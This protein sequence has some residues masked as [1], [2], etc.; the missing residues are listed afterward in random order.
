MNAK[1]ILHLGTYKTGTSSI[2]QTLRRNSNNLKEI[3]FL[4]PLPPSE[5]M[6]NQHASM[7]DLLDSE[8]N[9]YELT[10]YLKEVKKQAEDANCKT[11]IFSTE[12]FS[13]LESNQVVVLLDVLGKVISKDIKSILYFRNIEDYKLSTL[14]QLI[15]TPFNNFYNGRF[16]QQLARRLNYDAIFEKW[17]LSGNDLVVRAFDEHRDTVT[18]FLTELEIDKTNIEIPQ[19]LNRSLPFSLLL[20]LVVGNIIK[21]HEDHE[22]I[23]KK[24]KNE[25][26]KKD[27]IRLLPGKFAL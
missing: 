19:S 23:L 1:I 22:Y 21:N 18:S 2:Q 9:L 14:S 26:P 16:R 12:A 3:G 24:F 15:K 4:Y 10:E 13:S 11:I 6:I 7:C 25:K 8:R 5:K 17:N 20:S 27:R